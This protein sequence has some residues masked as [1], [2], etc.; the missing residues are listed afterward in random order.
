MHP[1]TNTKSMLTTNTKKN[2]YIISIKYYILLKQYFF[3]FPKKKQIISR[4]INMVL[5]LVGRSGDWCWVY[6]WYFCY[7]EDVYL[8]DFHVPFYEVFCYYH[9][10]WFEDFHLKMDQLEDYLA[11]FLENRVFYVLCVSH[12]QLLLQ[13]QL[14]NQIHLL[15]LKNTLL[16]RSSQVMATA[17]VLI[18]G[19]SV[20]CCMRCFMA[21]HLSGEKI[22]RGHLPTSCTKT[23]P[24]QV[25]SR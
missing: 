24:F 13:N 22:G 4:C 10:Q 19:L 1:K 6:C 21:V 25:A 9:V 16:R 12:R 7:D 15:E 14:R 5:V 3:L 20:F 2:Y 11:E 17:V 8:L 23:S 18:G